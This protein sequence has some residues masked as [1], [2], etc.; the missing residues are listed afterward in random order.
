MEM[1]PTTL[2]KQC[3]SSALS[4]CNQGVRYKNRKIDHDIAT[5][6]HAQDFEVISHSPNVLFVP[7]EGTNFVFRHFKIIS[8]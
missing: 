7:F 8:G 1:F 2:R 6:T 3:S 5:Q 4:H